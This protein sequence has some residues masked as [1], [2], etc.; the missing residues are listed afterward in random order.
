MFAGL[1]RVIAAMNARHARGVTVWDAG[2]G[3]YV[4][5]LPELQTLAL[6]CDASRFQAR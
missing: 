5:V 4:T 3:R 6:N 2:D 1:D